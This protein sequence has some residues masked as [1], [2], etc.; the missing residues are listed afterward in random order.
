M[1]KERSVFLETMG[2]GKSAHIVRKQVSADLL[3]E[4]ESMT[5]DTLMV[6]SPTA[7]SHRDTPLLRAGWNVAQEFILNSL[8]L[9]NHPAFLPYTVDFFK[10]MNIKKAQDIWS[11]LTSDRVHMDPAEGN[12]LFSDPA[13]RVSSVQFYKARELNGISNPDL[14]S[15]LNY[16]SNQVPGVGEFL[17]QFCYPSKPG[18]SIISQNT[19]LTESS[20]VSSFLP[21]AMKRLPKHNENADF[22]RVSPRVSAR[23]RKSDVAVEAA[24]KRPVLREHN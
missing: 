5:R 2:D 7:V 23:K 22:R 13:S 11:G 16:L 8:F 12:L 18:M 3:K 9:S 20:G 15:F 14:D 1:L 6:L 10:D 17:K 24:T 21:S 4:L 19:E